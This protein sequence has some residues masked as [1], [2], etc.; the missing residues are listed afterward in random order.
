MTPKESDIPIKGP[1]AIRHLVPPAHDVMF[2]DGS[3]LHRSEGR[4][5]HLAD[6]MDVCLFGR[7]LPGKRPIFEILFD[8]FRKGRD[9]GGDLRSLRT[10]R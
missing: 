6:A 10:A 7:R 9:L 3:D 2:A 4:D 8:Q 5:E 1:W